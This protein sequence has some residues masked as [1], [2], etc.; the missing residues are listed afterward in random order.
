M[1]ETLAARLTELA[2]ISPAAADAYQ[3]HGARLV[4]AVDG[5][6]RAHE[7]RALLIGSNPLGT[8]YDNHAN[9]WRFMRNCFASTTRS[10]WPVSS[11]GC[12]GRT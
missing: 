12:T 6:L 7:D 8:A 5:A 2:P 3:V 9:H 10:F 4:S 11:R 1:H